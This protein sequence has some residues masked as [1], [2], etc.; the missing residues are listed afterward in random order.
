MSLARQAQA[1]PTNQ[2]YRC[3]LERLAKQVDFSVS[4]YFS[5]VNFNRF[6]EY[7]QC[8]FLMLVDLLIWL[9]REGLCHVA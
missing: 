4:K 8:L 6:D 1:F 3:T 5:D 9:L 7:D 2:Q